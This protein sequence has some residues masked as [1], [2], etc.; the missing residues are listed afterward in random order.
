MFCMCLDC[1]TTYLVYQQQP[2]IVKQWNLKVILVKLLMMEIL[3][4]L[5][6]NLE[7]FYLKYQKILPSSYATDAQEQQSV[8]RTWHH[9]YG[10]FG[11]SNLEKLAKGKLVDVFDYD[12]SRGISICHACINGK[13][14]RS[15]FPTTRGR[16]QKN[17]LNV[18]IVMFVI[19]CK[20]HHWVEVIILLPSLMTA[21]DMCGCTY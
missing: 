18:F 2:S 5:V 14:H 15:Q 8:E 11:S 16:Q 17:H 21:L 20:H 7:S 19:R 4:V 6:L 9:R 13:L 1:P 12:P 10:Y 3:L